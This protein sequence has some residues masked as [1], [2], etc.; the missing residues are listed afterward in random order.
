MK[1]LNY[2]ACHEMTEF[3]LIKDSTRQPTLETLQALRPAVDRDYKQYLNSFAT[4]Q[5]LGDL[6]Y[7]AAEETALGHCFSSATKAKSDLIARILKFQS[8]TFQ[9]ICP[10]CQFFTFSSIAHYIPKTEYP[11]LCVLPKNLLPC[12]AT[13]NSVKNDFW[14]ENGQ[15]AFL[16]FYL[17]TLPN[18]SFL[19]GNLTWVGI[20]P[21]IQFQ[22]VQNAGISN[23]L[24]ALVTSHFKFLGLISLYEIGVPRVI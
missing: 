6:G 17:D 21:T 20:I 19:Q 5:H 24:F 18:V 4:V 7:S 15:R 1:N 3:D 9:H 13:C 23:S 10:Y 8:N 16:H 14:R 12:C 22:L 11:S 2:I